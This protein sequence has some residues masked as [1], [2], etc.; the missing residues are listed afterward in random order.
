MRGDAWVY[1]ELV[2]R[3]LYI[4]GSRDELDL[5]RELARIRVHQE[6]YDPR[7]DR[8]EHLVETRELAGGFEDAL[9]AKPVLLPLIEQQAAKLSIRVEK[10]P[11]LREY[12]ERISREIP[13]ADEFP[14]RLRQYQL[15]AW[16]AF[17]KRGKAMVVLPTG[18]GKTIV[19]LYAIWRLRRPT[20]V[21]VPTTTLA[22]QWLDQLR[23]VARNV[24][25]YQ[26]GRCDVT[27]ATYQAFNRASELR[28]YYL[29]VSD[30]GH[31]LPADK[32]SRFVVEGV[33][34]A[35]LVLSA[36]PRRRDMNHELLEWFVGYNVFVKTYS[37][38]AAQGWVA[39]LEV[40]VVKVP[41]SDPAEVQR[42]IMA[43]SYAREAGS[44]AA[45]AKAKLRMK[46]L[47]DPSKER[48]LVEMVRASGSKAIVF[49]EYVEQAYRLARELGADAITGR[50]P[51]EARRRA[52]ARFRSGLSRV[53]V[54]T[55]AAEEGVDLPDAEEA[56]M[57]AVPGERQLVQR[58]G[59]IMRPKPLARAVFLLTSPGQDQEV[60]K[61]RRILAANG[62]DARVR[63]ARARI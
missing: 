24:C 28:D 7:R 13:V 19:A 48:L 15:E 26:E 56:Y 17:K 29:L 6:S 34:P 11:R 58:L 27:V 60:G 23:M 62:V 4:E 12:L 10:G 37:E 25:F 2:G 3:N 55:S 1:V 16:E 39:P 52:V 57:L 49:A 38:L 35:R 21:L 46:L 59:R 20:L 43:Y 31:H 45:R 5:V 51:P 36:T 50:E 42:L 44:G 54:V 14:W 53:L 30:E 63:V 61:L 22:Q 33:W 18:T 9:V 8:V 40:L 41:P 47:E 32:W